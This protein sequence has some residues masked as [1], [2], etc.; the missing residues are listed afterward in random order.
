MWTYKRYNGE[1]ISIQEITDR[2][3]EV[4]EE[5][6]AS[7]RRSNV[8][9]YKELQRIQDELSLSLRKVFSKHRAYLYRFVS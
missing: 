3:I 2:F 6:L 1:R 7:P 5:T 9:L 4:D 8:K